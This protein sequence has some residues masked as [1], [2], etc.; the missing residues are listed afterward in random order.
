MP[1]TPL[2]ASDIELVRVW[3]ADGATADCDDPDTGT[4]V[5]RYH[6]D[7]WAEPD[8]HGMAAKYQEDTCL[9]CHGAD[10]TGVGAAL[11][12]DTC[13]TPDDPQA[14]RTDCTFCH[15]GED[16][17][18]G[19]PPVDINNS[20]AGLSFSAHTAHVTTNIHGAYDCA[21]CHQKPVD[22]LSYGHFLVGDITAGVAEVDFSGGLSPAASYT[23]GSCSSLYCHGD[24]Q[25]DNGSWSVS[26]G[27]PDCGD[28]HASRASGDDAWDRMSDDHD[29]HLEEGITCSE[30]HNLTA[31]SAENIVTPALHVNG[32]VE[33]GFDASITANTAG[34][35]VSC[36]GSCHGETHEVGEHSW[37]D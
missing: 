5:A 16:N 11:S 23:P 18:T 10:L 37:Y 21:Q 1:S 34:A 8:E 29:K 14:W 20:A 36:T 24:G 27:T 31:D 4:T 2:G 32:S 26:Q 30:C 28:C 6:P 17:A 3:I 25:G 13:H 12:C 35:G 15:G 33:L 9:D 22:V 19:A 7:G